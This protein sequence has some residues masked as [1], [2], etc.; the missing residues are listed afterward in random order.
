MADHFRSLAVEAGITV[1]ATPRS[2]DSKGLAIT[3]KQLDGI[4]VRELA[5]GT[6]DDEFDWRVEAVRKGHE[7]YQVT[8]PWMRSDENE[9]RA[10]EKRSPWDAFAAASFA[11]RNAGYNPAGL[12]ATVITFA[13]V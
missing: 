13:G 2:A 10:W 1:H 6:S 7:D 9:S 5:G 8:R 3:A 11:R 12:G 4:E